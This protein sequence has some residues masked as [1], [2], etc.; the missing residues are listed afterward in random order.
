VF[1]AQLTAQRVETTKARKTLEEAV[2]EM[3][4]IQVM[5]CNALRSSLM[6]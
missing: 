3:E 5:L 4:L 2:H 6:L 1:E